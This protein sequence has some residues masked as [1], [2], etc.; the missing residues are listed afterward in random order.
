[1]ATDTRTRILEAALNE[2]NLLGAPNV[3]SNALAARLGI[4]PGN[5]YYHFRTKDEIIIA[6]FEVFE[7]EM[8]ALMHIPAAERDDWGSGYRYLERVGELQWKYQFIFRDM[9]ELMTANRQLEKRLNRLA[10]QTVQVAT[11][12]VERLKQTAGMRIDNDEQR[13]LTRNMALVFTYWPQFDFVLNSR[14]ETDTQIRKQ[15]LAD[16]IL[17]LQSML[18]PYLPPEA[19]ERFRKFMETS[20]N[21]PAD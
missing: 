8:L 9:I 14:S 18:L 7:R 21:S 15:A 10:H 19:R 1:M 16:Q 2:F 20:V 5:L 17:D 13:A 4:S 12:L 3:S 11:T 6:L